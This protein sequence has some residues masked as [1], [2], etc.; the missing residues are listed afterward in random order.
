MIYALG[1]TDSATRPRADTL[2]QQRI[3]RL[4]RGTR[5]VRLIGEGSAN[6][7]FEFR[8]PRRNGG[9]YDFSGECLT[10]CSPFDGFDPLADGDSCRRSAL[11]GG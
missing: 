2:R 8:V 1:G 3:R 11:E 10:S 9:G 4:P 6:A 7:V 5:P